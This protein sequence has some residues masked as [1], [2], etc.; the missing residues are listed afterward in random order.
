MTGVVLHMPVRRAGPCSS[1]RRSVWFHGWA[2]IWESEITPIVP[3]E[4]AMRLARLHLVDDVRGQTI[5]NAPQEVR[6]AKF[7]T[8]TL[9]KSASRLHIRISGHTE[10]RSDGTWLLPESIWVPQHEHPHAMRTDLLGRAAFD[11]ESQSFAEFELFAR[12]EWSGRTQFNG[13][14]GDKAHG[15]IGCIFTLA[16][17]RDTSRVPLGF[18]G[19]DDRKL[20][21]G[22]HGCD[23]GDREHGRAHP[24]ADTGKLWLAHVTLKSGVRKHYGLVRQLA[25]YESTKPGGTR[26]VSRRGARVKMQPIH[27]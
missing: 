27:P 1:G 21:V 4:I 13:R 6:S 18:D 20:N 17:R 23:C 16:P 25:L 24:I 9:S 3:P 26:D 10:A 5:P 8:E 7:K 12:G 22:W 14:K 15:W 11:L 2:T 19:S